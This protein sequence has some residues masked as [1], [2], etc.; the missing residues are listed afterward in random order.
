MALI[1]P[2]RKR[3]TGKIDR[4]GGRGFRGSGRNEGGRKEEGCVD[5][6]LMENTVQCDDWLG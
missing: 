2:E 3:A 6:R 1:D 4:E 5:M